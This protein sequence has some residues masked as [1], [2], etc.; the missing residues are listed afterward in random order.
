MFGISAPAEIPVE[1]DISASETEET[2]I[3]FCDFESEFEFGRID[4]TAGIDAFP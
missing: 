1:S 4:R 3:F 2:D